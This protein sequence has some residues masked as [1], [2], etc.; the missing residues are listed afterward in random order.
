V[1]Y[2]VEDDIQPV[3]HVTRFGLVIFYSGFL[4]M[5]PDDHNLKMISV[6]LPLSL[7]LFLSLSLS[8]S[9]SLETS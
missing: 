2:L 3:L 9:L 1:I 6:S 8:L 4:Q 5:D 7:S